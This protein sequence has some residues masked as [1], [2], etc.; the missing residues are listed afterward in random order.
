MEVVNLKSAYGIAKVTGVA[1]CLGGVFLI[2]FFTGP[3]LSPINHHHAFHSGQTSSAPPGRM[4][5]I[6]GTFLKI[7]G[8][9]IWSLWITL[10][11]CSWSSVHAL[12]YWWLMQLQATKLFCITNL[13]NE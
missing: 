10:Q 2:A 7:L 11:V 4:T 12:D 13:I 6:K 3:S 8:D 1:L 5:W 9:M